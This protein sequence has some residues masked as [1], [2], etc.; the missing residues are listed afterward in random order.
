MGK[1]IILLSSITYAIK[2]RDLLFKKGIRAHVERIS[3]NSKVSGC[4]YGIYVP[5][6]TDEAEEILRKAGVRIVGRA[7]RDEIK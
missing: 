7:E 5:D 2:S 1:P 6:R 4:G 3:S